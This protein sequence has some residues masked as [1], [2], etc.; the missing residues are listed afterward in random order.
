MKKLGTVFAAAAL[1]CAML[2]TSCGSFNYA[3][4]DLSKYVD[5]GTYK[6][7]TFERA[8]VKEI[9]D[10][11][12]KE[13]L[14]SDFSSN[15]TKID[16]EEGYE[17]KNGDFLTVDYTGKIDGET[18]DGGSATDS[19]IE[20]GAGKLIEG[21]EEGLIGAKQDD[22]VT[23]NLTFPDPYENNEALSG[24]AVVFE[25]TV[26]NIQKQ[27][28]EYST[29][30]AEGTA[31]SDGDVAKIDFVI[32]VDGQEADSDVAVDVVVG[33]NNTGVPEELCMALKG[34]LV[35]AKDEEISITFPEDY[36]DEEFRG[37]T[38]VCTVSVT[39]AK[40]VHEIDAVDD[41]FIAAVTEYTTLADYTEKVV[42]VTLTKKYEKEAK[43]AD[44]SGIWKKV[45]DAATVKSFPSSEIKKVSDSLYDSVAGMIGNY[46][47]LSMREYVKQIGYSSLKDYRK[48]VCDKGAEEI[49]KEKIVLNAIVKAENLSLTEEEKA[50]GL[51]TY[52]ED[53]DLGLSSSYETYEEFEKAVQDG[54]IRT[55]ALY[56]SLLWEKVVAFLLDSA[57]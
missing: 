24:K 5:L 26:K 41:A 54:T 56:D 42:N 13:Q 27:V 16:T 19:T 9:T 51:K 10:E 50:A 4:E 14:A 34:V 12:I 38:G 40:V 17:A 6:G 36:A 28:Y 45:L 57:K 7:I 23:L 32:M 3:K 35:G 39:S 49:V 48:N 18:F 8:E 44:F 46:Y 43:T 33:T 37:K 22:I 53:E 15:I 55:E 20:I 11:A 2:L 25:V 31:L 47:N 52:Y 21:F 30:I 1:S 29:D